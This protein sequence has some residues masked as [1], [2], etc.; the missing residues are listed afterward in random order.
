MPTP[1]EFPDPNQTYVPYA[2]GQLNYVKILFGIECEIAQHLRN[3]QIIDEMK[4]R[5]GVS[6]REEK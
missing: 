5:F 6:N 1:E 3:Q 4:R 2:R